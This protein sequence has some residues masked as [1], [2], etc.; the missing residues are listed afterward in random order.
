MLEIVFHGVGQ[1]GY[2]GAKGPFGLLYVHEAF[3]KR[4]RFH[5]AVELRMSQGLVNVVEIHAFG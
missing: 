1:P 2:A 5:I 3:L 4:N